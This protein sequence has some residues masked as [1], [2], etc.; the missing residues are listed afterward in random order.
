MIDTVLDVIAGTVLDLLI[1]ETVQEAT[2]SKAK[3][4]VRYILFS[5]ICFALAILFFV[6]FYA[7]IKYIVIAVLF[8]ILAA[9]SVIF[10]CYITYKNNQIKKYR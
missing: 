6:L 4:N 7:F 2:A 1:D 9:V 10:W 5:V 3:R 8:I